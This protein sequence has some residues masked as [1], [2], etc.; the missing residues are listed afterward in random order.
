MNHAVGP[1]NLASGK[2][3]TIREVVDIL[4]AHTGMQDKIVWDSNKPNG[5]IYRA[6][7]VSRLKA[8]G[9]DCK[10]TLEHALHETYNWYA[11]HSESV[12]H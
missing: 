4:A 9:F 8:I 3:H 10:Y 2:S 1:L 6:Y 7:D 11:A 12:R 5:I